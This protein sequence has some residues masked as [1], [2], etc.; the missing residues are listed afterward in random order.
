[1]KCVDNGEVRPVGALLESKGDP[2]FTL[3]DSSLLDITV[4]RGYIDIC[5]LLLE[6]G[7]DTEAAML[8]TILNNR[9]P[10]CQLLLESGADANQ[11]TTLLHTAVTQL[12]VPIC[13]I[14]IEHKANVNAQDE[15]GNTPFDLAWRER[16]HSADLILLFAKVWL[17]GCLLP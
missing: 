2:K 12:F 4:K 8:Q 16:R 1:M 9:A 17:I 11:P 3:H 15:S 7:A 6:Y 5:R 14:L 10:M 13:K